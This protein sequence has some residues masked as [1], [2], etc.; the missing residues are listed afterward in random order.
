ML[1]FQGGD[2]NSFDILFKKYSVSLINFAYR[3][4]GNRTKAEEVAQEVLLKVYTARKSYHPR[5]KFSTWLYRIA[6]NLCLNELRRQEYRQPPISF[7][8]PDKEHPDRRIQWTDYQTPTPEQDLER[9]LFEEAFSRAI[10][11]LPVRQR[12]AFVLNRFNNASYKDVAIV[13]GCSESSVKS[14]IHRAAVTLKDYLKD[15]IIKGNSPGFPGS[16][17]KCLSGR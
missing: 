14:L 9:K 8:T 16:P 1:E 7:D 3:F 15:Y 12:A 5:A 13:L 4:L 17:V 2:A 10:G 11:M 6:K